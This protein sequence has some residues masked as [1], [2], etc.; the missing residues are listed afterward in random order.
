MPQILGYYWHFCQIR[1]VLVIFR[2]KIFKRSIFRKIKYHTKHCH[3][4][5]WAKLAALVAYQVWKKI[6]TYT[7]VIVY[8][9]QKLSKYFKGLKTRIL[10]TNS[11]WL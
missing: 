7:V 6:H 2:M 11:K 1:C 10:T 3:N 4:P 9:D 5:F 8:M